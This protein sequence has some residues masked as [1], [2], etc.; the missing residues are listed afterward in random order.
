LFFGALGIHNF[1][2]GHYARGIIQL[3]LTLGWMIIGLAITIL[4]SLIE[5]I[6]ETGDGDGH[7]MT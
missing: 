6:V 1:Y 5:I 7:R 3:L 2:A 4:W